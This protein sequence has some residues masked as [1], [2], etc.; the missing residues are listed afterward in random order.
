M[1]NV[2]YVQ[3]APEARNYP[4]SQYTYRELHELKDVTSEIGKV[5]KGGNFLNIWKLE[6]VTGLQKRLFRHSRALYY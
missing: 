4:Q 1:R 6:N 2:D 5:S 3:M